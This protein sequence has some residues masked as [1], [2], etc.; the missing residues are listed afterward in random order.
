[1]STRAQVHIEGLS[2]SLYRH[3]DGYPESEHGV[4]AWLVP[5]VADFKKRRGWDPQYMLARALETGIRATGMAFPKCAVGWGIET[6][7]HGDLSFSYEIRR[8]FAIVVRRHSLA[9]ETVQ[10]VECAS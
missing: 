3:S 1:M 2:V 6:E 4:L 5:F 9:G 8:D 10:I 7:E